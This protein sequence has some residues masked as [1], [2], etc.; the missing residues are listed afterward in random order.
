MDWNK[1]LPEG[2]FFL[3]AI[4]GLLVAGIALIN[5]DLGSMIWYH[6]SVAVGVFTGLKLFKKFKT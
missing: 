4:I 2:P 1:L 3:F 6:L 5:Q